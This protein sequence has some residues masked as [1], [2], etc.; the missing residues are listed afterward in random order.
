MCSQCVRMPFSKHVL[1][2]SDASQNIM[3]DRLKLGPRAIEDIEQMPS[4]QSTARRVLQIQS[5]PEHIHTLG[6]FSL[7][8]LSGNAYSVFLKVYANVY[9]NDI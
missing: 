2:L 6:L 3:T 9:S 7:L 5:V 1:V 4:P 8:P